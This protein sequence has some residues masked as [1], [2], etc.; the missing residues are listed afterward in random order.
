MKIALIVQNTAIDGVT[1]FVLNMGSI[2]CRAG[3]EVTVV[4]LKQ[5][6][7][8]PRLAQAG[9]RGVYRPQARWESTI[10]Y[11]RRMARWLNQERFNLLLVNCGR[12]L[13]PVQLGL[14]F[15][16]D[17]MTVVP[18]VHNDRAGVYDV[19]ELNAEAWNVAV[20]VSPQV[21]R[22]LQTRQI[23]RPMIYIPYGIDLPAPHQLQARAAWQKPLRLV[24][25]GRLQDR[26]KNVQLLPDILAA[27][28]RRQIDVRLTVV[29]DGPDRAC[30]EQRFAAEG[31]AEQVEMRGFQPPEEAYQ[32]MREHHVLL[33]PSHFEG[34][35]LVLLEAQANG[36]V[37][38]ASLLSGIT[39]VGIQ[40]R[41]SGW[42][43]APNDAGSVAEGIAA[44]QEPAFWQACSR[45]GIE[46]AGKL[47]STQVM[48]ERYL[49]LIEEIQQDTYPL[50][51]SRSALRKKGRTLFTAGDYL[52]LSLRSRL[53]RLRRQLKKWQER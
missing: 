41:V 46:R 24:Y 7:W 21:Q 33:L 42:L 30:L 15:L 40:D 11:V 10:G 4:T 52:P 26:Q 8:W 53:R 18:I 14:P 36:C 1:T 48:G 2:L 38:V 17:D 37:P 35:P 5:G 20:A 23:E 19:V 22:V 29:G 43:A 32:A 45:A 50:L 39:D 12:F 3:H 49:R 6:D 16:A 34:L 13:K 31:V 9:L 28:R 51:F 44:L 27:C 47:F 25:V